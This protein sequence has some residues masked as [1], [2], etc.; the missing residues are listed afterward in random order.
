MGE[1]THRCSDDCA[2]DGCW[3]EGSEDQ[4]RDQER[5]DALDADDSDE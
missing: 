1:I 3:Y 4:E 2:R 5:I